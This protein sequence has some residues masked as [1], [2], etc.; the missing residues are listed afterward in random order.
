M[1][2]LALKGGKPVAPYGLKIEWPVLDETDKY[3]VLEAL[4]SGRWCSLTHGPDTK[5]GQFE[6]AFAQYLGVKYGLLVNN[7]T[8]AIALALK[9]GGVGHGDEVIVPAVT[10]IATATA[11]VQI[12]AIPVFADI[13]PETYQIDPSW[14]RKLITPRT[15]AIV[16]VHYGGYPANMDEIMEIAKEHN[17]VVVEDCAEAHGSEWRGRKVGSIGHLGAFSFQQGK[18]LTCG[19][20]G[21][22][23]TNDEGLY[24]KCLSYANF[25]RLPGRPVYEHHVIGYN[26]RMTEIQAALLLSQFRRLPY[27]TE[28]RHIN[29]E[30]LAMELEKIGGVS[31][32]KRDPRITKRGYYFYF[33]RYDASQFKGVTRD[34]FM[35]AL[36][37]EGIPCGTAHNDPVYK[38][39]A[40]LELKSIYGIPVDYTKVQCPVSERIYR[41]EVIA[42]GKDFLMKRENVDLVL[43]AIRKIKENVEELIE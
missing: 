18:P 28:I 35:R 21:F 41:N 11:V 9:A 42:L 34:L 12:G 30:Y 23:S 13:D 40:F 33:I 39:P 27:Q 17:L 4:V 3:A 8:N 36:R 19:E 20:G 16:P 31:A 22:V 2:E 7:G 14:I 1:A 29:G 6:A 25:G 24:A 38:N 15:K 5:N 26:M 43:E 10:F 32:L 37:A